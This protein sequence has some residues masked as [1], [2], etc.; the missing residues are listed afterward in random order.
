MRAP[1][2]GSRN[3]DTAIICFDVSIWRLTRQ[4]NPNRNLVA[5]R[6][7]VFSREYRWRCIEVFLRDADRSRL[8]IPVSW[9]NRCNLTS[10]DVTGDKTKK[11]KGER[12]RERKV[13]ADL[14]V[15]YADIRAYSPVDGEQIFVCN[16]VTSRNF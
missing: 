6:C 11:K 9:N 1:I 3:R 12:E 2:K 15:T 8:F 16:A 5:E 13:K 4:E 14:L 7:S 10:L